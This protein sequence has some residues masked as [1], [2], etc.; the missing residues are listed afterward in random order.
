[1]SVN[2]CGTDKKKDF[3]SKGY[4]SIFMFQKWCIS[5]VHIF[6]SFCLFKILYNF[7]ISIFCK[8][9]TKTIIS[10]REP[11]NL[12]KLCNG[13]LSIR[14][15][16]LLVWHFDSNPKTQWVHFKHKLSS[17]LS[18]VVWLHH[19]YIFKKNKNGFSLSFVLVLV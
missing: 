1:M 18:S 2:Y 16:L 5:L 11:P 12:S 7:V 19:V 14:W 8:S 6:N 3:Y 9:V 4:L 10:F 17:S 15:I 13:L